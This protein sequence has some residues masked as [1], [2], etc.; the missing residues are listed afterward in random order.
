MNQL[1]KH[2]MLFFFLIALLL[3]ICPS[4]AGSAE[5]RVTNKLSGNSDLQIHCKSKNEDLGVHVIPNQGLYETKIKTDFWG[6]TLYFCGFVWNNKLH[7]FDIYDYQRDKPDCAY[8]CWWTVQE[9]GP[10]KIYGIY[11]TNAISN[12]KNETIKCYPWNNNLV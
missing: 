2:A 3:V 9:T 10:C 7:W 11:N 6:K 8:F 1:F 5:V 4:A 12:S